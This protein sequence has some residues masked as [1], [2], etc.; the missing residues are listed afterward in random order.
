[1]PVVDGYKQP[2]R[3]ANGSVTM[4]RPRTP[5]IALTAAAM[6]GDMEK[7]PRRR[8]RLPRHQ[9]DF[10]SGAAGVCSS[11]CS[12]AMPKRRRRPNHMTSRRTSSDPALFAEVS[13]LFLD[14]M[15]RLIV[16][17]EAAFADS[18]FMKSETTF[19]PSRAA[20]LWWGRNQLS[21]YLQG[22]RS[23]DC[24]RIDAGSRT[25][26]AELHAKPARGGFGKADESR[27]VRSLPRSPKLSRRRDLDRII[28][29]IQWRLKS[30]SKP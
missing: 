28:R 15:D 24:E 30:E 19:I 1:M 27:S 10:Q 5:I 22:T 13:Q 3:S 16:T 7:Q 12:R 6:A 29:R 20:R 23:C 4:M 14:E 17:I 9:A 11:R 2:P 26:L 25:Q 21:R 8:M 18:D